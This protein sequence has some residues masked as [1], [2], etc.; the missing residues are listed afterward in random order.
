[1]PPGRQVIIRDWINACRV[2]FEDDRQSELEDGGREP[3]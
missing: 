3:A 2:V 1:M